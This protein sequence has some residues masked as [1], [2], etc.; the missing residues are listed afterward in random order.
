[1]LTSNNFT[2]MM[3][4]S[5]L[6][7]LFASNEPINAKLFNYF[8]VI[9]QKYLQVSSMCT[10]VTEDKSKMLH[11]LLISLS[12]CNRFCGLANIS[13]PSYAN[14]MNRHVKEEITL[15]QSAAHQGVLVHLASGNSC[16]HLDIFLGS[17]M[18]LTENTGCK[19]N[20]DLSALGT[21]GLGQT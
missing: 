14:T 3:F 21:A 12:F 6:F 16:V 5:V 13:A 19:M 9:R 2:A 10:F 8:Q 7:L 20:R 1:M 18:F 11:S 17:Y 15:D 4:S